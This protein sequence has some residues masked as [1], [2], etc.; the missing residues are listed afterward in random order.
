MVHKQSLN[1][2]EVLTIIFNFN[3]GFQSRR[4]DY[5]YITRTERKIVF[6]YNLYNYLNHNGDIF[7]RVAIIF[8]N[9]IIK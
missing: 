4:V 2:P 7:S 6:T 8:C 9:K 5:M 1:P 3:S